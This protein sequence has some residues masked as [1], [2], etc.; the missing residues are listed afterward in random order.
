MR[1]F[2]FA[3]VLMPA[4]ALAQPADDWTIT[5]MLTDDFLP[6][7]LMH[8]ETGFVNLRGEVFAS[9][10]ADTLWVSTYQPSG[11]NG[12]ELPVQVKVDRTP[13]TG[14]SQMLMTLP[15]E[16]V[17][18][19]NQ[20]FGMSR[21]AFDATFGPDGLN[22]TRLENIDPDAGMAVTEYHECPTGQVGRAAIVVLQALPDT[23]GYSFFQLKLIRFDEASCSTD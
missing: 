22:W 19:G 10:G 3:L 17:G 8:S 14:I 18:F 4:M 9:N 23:P 15:S 2:L 13:G 1:A 11:P 6:A 12:A 16:T 5:S 21:E 7:A 20:M